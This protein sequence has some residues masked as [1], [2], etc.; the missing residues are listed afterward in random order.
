MKNDIWHEMFNLVNHGESFVTATIVDKSGSAPRSSGAR[1]VVRSGG[2]IIGTVGGGRL[3]AEA[4]IAAEAV[5]N[6]KET[7]IHP[8]NLSGVDA[9]LSDMIC[10]GVGELL[11]DYFD[12]ESFANREILETL[13]QS[14]EKH[15]KAWLITG[16]GMGEHNRGIRQQCLIRPMGEMTGQFPCSQDFFL[17]M[18]SGPAKL[19]IHSEVLEDLRVFI[20]PIH[21]GGTLYIFGAGHV[22]QKIAPVAETVGFRTVILDDRAE[23]ANGERFPASKVLLLESLEKPL[24]ALPF[25][26]DSYLVIVTRGHLHDKWILEQTLKEPVAYIG[27]IGSRHKRD[28]VYKNL[29][30]ERGYTAEDIQRVHCPIGLDILAESPE[31]IA[32]SIVAEL[33]R[34]RGEKSHAPA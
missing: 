29:I 34:V 4:I 16:I 20:E 5:F 18:I 22:S 31:E 14:I 12:G 23:F 25:D 17:R 28:L 33:I 27:M 13:I 1:M 19:A 30:E 15:E 32:I 26:R 3:E 6:T 9:A 24:P 2:R 8:F 21:Q 11:L 10:G 7:V